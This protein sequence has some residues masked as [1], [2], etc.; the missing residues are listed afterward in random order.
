MEKFVDAAKEGIQLEQNNLFE[1][2]FQREQRL[3]E[4]TR[5]HI[6]GQ[7]VLL[8][9]VLTEIQSSCQDGREQLGSQL[10]SGCPPQ[11]ALQHVSKSNSKKTRGFKRSNVLQWETAAANSSHLFLETPLVT[12]LVECPLE[13]STMFGF[14]CRHTSV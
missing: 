3:H 7:F 12:L 6:D 8:G 1:A 2:S 10:A 13:S 9:H 5:E 4:Q 14:V 11:Q